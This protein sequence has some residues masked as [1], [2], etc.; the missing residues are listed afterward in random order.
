MTKV[1]IVTDKLS[2]A[3]EEVETV[4]ASL[5]NSGYAVTIINDVSY[6]LKLDEHWDAYIVWID[7]LTDSHN[8]ARTIRE[9]KTSDKA[10]V[11]I[12][13]WQPSVLTLGGGVSI[14]HNTDYFST[15]VHNMIFE[16]KEA[17]KKSA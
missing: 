7:S 2:N 8:V 11:S 12:A 13:V 15:A 3:D 5:V 6:S 14:I 9:K 10:R 17:Q 16:E 4:N 1:L